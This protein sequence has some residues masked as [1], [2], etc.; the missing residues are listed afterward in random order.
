LL[1]IY[2]LYSDTEYYTLV[3]SAGIPA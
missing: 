2:R 3:M 1:Y